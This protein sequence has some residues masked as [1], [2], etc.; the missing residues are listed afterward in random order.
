MW[1]FGYGSLMADG[2]EGKLGCLRRCVATLHGYRRIFN[3]ASTSNR[4]TKEFPCPTLNL[5]TNETGLCTGI[6]FEFPDNRAGDVREYLLNRE[7]KSFP[8]ESLPIHLQDD[9]GVMA[10]V[11]VY[12]GK[13]LLS[14]MTA[15]T[16]AGM[17][18]I[19]V[20]TQ[21][22]CRDY[23]KQIAEALDNLGIE[24]PAVSELWNAVQKVP[25]ELS[26]NR[27]PRPS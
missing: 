5:E 6:A 25:P 23:V 18:R 20:G 21:S 16:R 8:L 1:V 22:S 11:P 14:A 17:I 26:V 10:L 2:W 24:D 9:A 3:K 27:D 19:A 4:G 15:D 7:G 12:R 13:N